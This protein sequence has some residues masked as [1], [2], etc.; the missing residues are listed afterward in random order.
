M[1]PNLYEWKQEVT[2]AMIILINKNMDNYAFKLLLAIATPESNFPN[3]FVKQLINKDKPAEEVIKF[4]EEIFKQ[5]I[6]LALIESD[7]NKNSFVQPQLFHALLSCF[8]NKEEGIW[9]TLKKMFQFGVPADLNIYSNYVFPAVTTSCPES[10]LSEIEKTGHS[11]TTAIDPLLK[12]YCYH[13]EFANAL[14][15]IQKYPVTLSQSFFNIENFVN[16]RVHKDNKNNSEVYY[17]VISFLLKNVGAFKQDH[18]VAFGRNLAALIQINPSL[19]ENLLDNSDKQF[20]V[21]N[22]SLLICRNILRKKNPKLLNY[23]RRLNNFESHS[24]GMTD[25]EEVEKLNLL[26]VNISLSFRKGLSTSGFL[27]ECLHFYLKQKNIPKINELKEEL[28]KVTVQYPPSLL[29]EL[30]NF[31]SANGD[32]EQAQKSFSDLK[33][34]YPS[35]KLDSVKV[36]S[37]ASLLIKYSKFD[38][39]I[40]VVNSESKELHYTAI[41]SLLKSLKKLLTIAVETGSVDLVKNLQSSLL[42]HIEFLHLSYFHDPLLKICLYKNDL[43][44]AIE[45]FRRCIENHQI[46]PCLRLIMKKCIIMENPVKLESVIQIA[47]TLLGRE[48]VLYELVITLLKFNRESEAMKVM[49]NLRTKNNSGCLEDFCINMYN[50]NQKEELID[51]VKFIC[52][53][54][55]VNRES[56]VQCKNDFK[57]AVNLYNVTKDLFQLNDETRNL[58]FNLISRNKQNVPFTVPETNYE[59]KTSFVVSE[60]VSKFLQNMNEEDAHQ[61]LEQLQNMK[62]VEV[63]SISV[64]DMSKFLDML[65]QKRSLNDLSKNVHAMDYIKDNMPKILKPLLEKYSSSGDVDAINEMKKNFPELAFMKNYYSKAYIV[66][67]R[68]EDL[69]FAYENNLNEARSIFKMSAFLDILK[70]PHLEGRAISLAKKYK[71]QDFDLPIAA[72]WAHCLTNE[73]YR[74]AEEFCKLFSISAH[75]VGRMVSKVAREKENVTMAMNYLS[76]IKDIDCQ[77]KHKENAY[78]TLLDILVLK[79]MYDD[80]S[81]LVVEAQEKDIN[82]EKHYR[83]TL[84]MLKNALQRERKNVPFTI[85]SEDFAVPE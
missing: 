11:V 20:E 48:V 35:F 28:D 40:N 8:K 66:S 31:H 51:F 76:A 43:N 9:L 83:S 71:E 37:Y 74:K 29:S 50:L 18:E 44:G 61:A 17:Q 7:P 45:E 14:Y 67:E 39:A 10:V 32:L 81:L 77:N 82:L 24:K 25:A 16:S 47:S 21:S 79:E 22:K 41:S 38:D 23:I 56:I 68:Y 46:A 3:L 6:L 52:V 30:L 4:C 85:Q 60:V 59:G 73:H 80:A 84:V 55:H 58:L 1:M 70:R 49:K 36:F 26:K 15:I 63:R 5:E 2:N 19:F 53:A 33:E 57:T 78:G 64:D 65:L 75:L 42:N 62:K 72:V 34:N 54:D 27:I 13:G 69:L 12:Y